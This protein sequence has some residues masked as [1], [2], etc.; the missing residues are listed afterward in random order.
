MPGP[1]PLPPRRGA[2]LAWN[3]FVFVFGLSVAALFLFLY[4]PKLTEISNKILEAN[5]ADFKAFQKELEH[6]SNVSTKK[7]VK[8]TSPLPSPSPTPKKADTKKDTD[9]KKVSSKSNLKVASSPKP[10]MS[11]QEAIGKTTKST[12]KSTEAKAEVKEIKS[13][14]ESKE[15]KEPK[16]IKQEV[17]SK[18]P[19]EEKEVKPNP[20]KEEKE[21]KPKEKSVSQFTSE[22]CSRSATPATS[23]G[24]ETVVVMDKAASGKAEIDKLPPGKRVSLGISLVVSNRT[25]PVEPLLESLFKSDVMQH[26]VTLFVWLNFPSR[27]NPST[28]AIL[29]LNVPLRVIA[30]ADVSNSNLHMVIPKIRIYETMKLL[31]EE[32]GCPFDFLLELHDDML[33]FPQWFNPLLNARF[34]FP[35]NIS[36]LGCAIIMPFVVRERRDGGIASMNLVDVEKKASV[37]KKEKILGRCA[38]VHPWLLNMTI[39]DA[40]G[41]YDEKY[42]PQEVEMDD[43]YFRVDQL[44][45]KAVAVQSSFV[46]HHAERDVQSSCAPSFLILRSPHF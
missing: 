16:E 28:D 46:Y 2:H 5:R 27:L 43:L 23:P 6:R 3:Y 22:L 19:N 15:V 17:K 37:F 4:A 30:I 26:D 7:G 11:K 1:V 36:V 31:G 20:I 10:A 45:F 8:E 35:C 29:K 40:I 41:Y 12:T 42:S 24:A 33:F 14:K 9:T 38:P 25:A 44:G 34:Q 13:P 32:S 18:Q 39:L 21:V